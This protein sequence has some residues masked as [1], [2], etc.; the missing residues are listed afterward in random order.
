VV[1]LAEVVRDHDEATTPLDHTLTHSHEIVE[2]P[3]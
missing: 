1:G 3:V 2:S